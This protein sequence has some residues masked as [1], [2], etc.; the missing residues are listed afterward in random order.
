MA[1][2]RQPA[3][4]QPLGAIVLFIV[5]LLLPI[6]GQI[7]ATVYIVG[8][9]WSWLVK[10]VLLLMVWSVPIIGP[11]VY[12]LILQKRNRVFPSLV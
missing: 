11:F 8:D 9:S 7:V 12:F 4:D 3:S 10:I 2:T 5:L 6:V 1:Y